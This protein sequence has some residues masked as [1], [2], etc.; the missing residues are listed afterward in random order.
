VGDLDHDGSVEVVVVLHH[1]PYCPTQ[2]ALLTPEGKYISSYWNFGYLDAGNLINPSKRAF[3]AHDIDTD[4]FDEILMGGTNN[5]CNQAVL[6]VLDP[7]HVQG[8]GVECTGESTNCD[9]QAYVLFP[10]HPGL[11]E[12]INRDRLQI[13]EI[14]VKIEANELVIRAHVFGP[15]TPYIGGNI[16]TYVLDRELRVLDRYNYDWFTKWARREYSKRNIS[17][18]IDSDHFRDMLTSIRVL[19]GSAALFHGS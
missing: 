17:F 1:T 10:N 6:I 14:A 18:D 5:S 7:R 11:L 16:W 3:V 12:G 13:S 8:L 19:P 2:V 9:A 15:T 4:G